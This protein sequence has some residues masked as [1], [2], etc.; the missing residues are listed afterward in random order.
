MEKEVLKILSKSKPRHKS[1]SV[2]EQ[3]EEILSK[4]FTKLHHPNNLADA[5]ETE[6]A[7]LAF[8]KKAI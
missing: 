5:C 3:D 8:D 7:I 2:K 1:N 4:I 6:N